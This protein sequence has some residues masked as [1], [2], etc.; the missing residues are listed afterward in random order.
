[1]KWLHGSLPLIFTHTFIF[2]LIYLFKPLVLFCVLIMSS[3]SRN[4]SFL[5]I[6]VFFTLNIPKLDFHV[7]FHVLDYDLIFPDDFFCGGSSCSADYRSIHKMW[8]LSC[9]CQI[10]T[11]FAGSRPILFNKN[12]WVLHLRAVL[13]GPSA[14]LQLNNISALWSRQGNCSPAF[15]RPGSEVFAEEPHF[16]G[17]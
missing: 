14:F 3:Y 15:F 6:V 13:T 4:F 1:M 8:F 10:V 5:I 7:Y 12:I 9:L 2:R 16:P 11:N 17:S